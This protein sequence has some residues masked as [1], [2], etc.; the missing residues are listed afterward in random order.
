MMTQSIQEQNL[1]CLQSF[2]DETH[3]RWATFRTSYT[4]Q[5]QRYCRKWV[6]DLLKNSES[7]HASSNH[8]YTLNGLTESY[9]EWGFV[10]LVCKRFREQRILRHIPEELRSQVRQLGLFFIV[11]ERYL[12]DQASVSERA[13]QREGRIHQAL[14]L[15]AQWQKLSKETNANNH[16]NL[17]HV[18]L[19]KSLDETLQRLWYFRCKNLILDDQKSFYRYRSRLVPTEDA[20]LQQHQNRQEDSSITNAP[21]AEEDELQQTLHQLVSLVSK[22][23]TDLV[24]W[25]AKMD[26]NS[27]ATIAKTLP[28]PSSKRMWTKGQVGGRW[29]ALTKRLTLLFRLYFPYQKEPLE[30]P[31]FADYRDCLQTKLLDQ[32]PKDF[33][34]ML[35]LEI[36]QLWQPLY[37]SKTPSVYYVV[38]ATWLECL[39]LKA[40]RQKPELVEEEWRHLALFWLNSINQLDKG[41]HGTRSTIH[42]WEREHQLRDIDHIA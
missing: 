28:S 12:A 35:P 30:Q 9:L 4:S 13:A 1:E 7:S 39:S 3:P 20:T 29:S 41:L 26:G 31:L 14:E 27:E 32:S 33:Y 8:P 42:N 36:R 10:E 16:P 40:L 24:I 15:A 17:S 25:R 23:E 38:H 19:D 11:A 34:S 21:S 37:K 2:N 5:L 18:P 6:K 22:D